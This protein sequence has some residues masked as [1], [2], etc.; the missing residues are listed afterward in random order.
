LLMYV[1][2]VCWCMLVMLNRTWALTAV[3]LAGMVVSPLLNLALIPPVLRRFGDGG[4]GVACAIACVA[5]EICVVSP[6]LYMLGRR[7]ADKRLLGMVVKSVGSAGLILVVDRLLD[8]YMGVYRLAVD[9]AG[10]VV[11]ILITRALNVRE[12][13]EFVRDIMKQRKE[14]PTLPPG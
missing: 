14:N 8:P 12:T 10:Y 3:F 11:L 4:G 2:V 5:T 6:M 9:L 7:L 1:S 13:V